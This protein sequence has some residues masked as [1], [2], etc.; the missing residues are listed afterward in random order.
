MKRRE[1]TPEEDEELIRFYRER[2]ETAIDEP[3]R[4]KLKESI[5]YRTE[6]IKMKRAGTLR[7]YQRIP[8]KITPKP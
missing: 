1:I 2:L 5:D 3:S 7:I 6:I 4:K 8:G